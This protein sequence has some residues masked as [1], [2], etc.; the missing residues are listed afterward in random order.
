MTLRYDF[1]V[2]SSSQPKHVSPRVRGEAGRTRQLTTRRHVR[3]TL[4]FPLGES[5]LVDLRV[6]V[7]SNMLDNSGISDARI[8]APLSTSCTS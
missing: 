7:R 8:H 4:I 3:L 5:P 6:V 1:P 2:M